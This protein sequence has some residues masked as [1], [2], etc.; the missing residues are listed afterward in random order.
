MLCESLTTLGLLIK[1]TEIDH[2]A[3]S[4][5]IFAAVTIG[6]NG[7]FIA[8]TGQILAVYISLTVAIGIL[9]S[10]PTKLLHKLSFAYGELLYPG[11]ATRRMANSQ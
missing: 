3:R 7:S 10:M 1:A 8:S 9:N 6:S 11:K 5:M 2:S 4:Q